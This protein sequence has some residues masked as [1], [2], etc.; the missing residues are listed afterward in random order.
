MAVLE[1]SLPYLYSFC[2]VLHGNVACSPVWN[3]RQD[4][5]SESKKL[6]VFQCEAY[7]VEHK[8]CSVLDAVFHGII[9]LRE[10]QELKTAVICHLMHK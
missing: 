9:F 2:L 1:T 4:I 5:A 6:G 8:R 3:V 7:V 10:V